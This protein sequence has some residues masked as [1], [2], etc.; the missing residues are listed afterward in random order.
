MK[1]Q[2]KLLNVCLD[3]KIP[4]FVLQGMDAC[5]VEILKAASDIYQR[6]GCSEEFQYDFKS[7]VNYF[8]IHQNENQS[9]FQLS[10][11]KVLETS[12]VE[13]KNLL[14]GCL[15]NEIPVIVFQGTDACSVEILKAA[16]DIYQRDGCSEEFQYD[17]KN[18]IDG[19]CGYQCENQETVKMPDLNQIEKELIQ[20]DKN[21]IRL[22]TLHSAIESTVMGNFQ[23]FLD[24]KQQGFKF[25]ET[26][27]NLLRD[28]L[29]SESLITVGCI[30]QIDISSAP[31][32]KIEESDKNIFINQLSLNR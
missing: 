16:S 26:E 31:S 25:S 21:N 22:S 5:S 6:N 32:L 18:L 8:S 27:V 20:E 19:F 2:R 15:N 13:K 7:L 12:A 1:D 11:L 9:S 28:N 14:N 17:F 24:L 3:N 30:F 10:S 23:P 29:N 4:A